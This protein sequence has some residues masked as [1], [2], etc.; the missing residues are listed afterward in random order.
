MRDLLELFLSVMVINR[1]A[2]R[3]TKERKIYLPKV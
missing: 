2:Q 1:K 3:I